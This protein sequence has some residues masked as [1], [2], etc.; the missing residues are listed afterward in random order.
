MA[1]ENGYSSPTLTNPAPTFHFPTQK[2]AI[3]VSEAQVPLQVTTP[4]EISIQVPAQ[5][6]VSV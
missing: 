3:K 1:I 5:E 6:K 2:I 4:K